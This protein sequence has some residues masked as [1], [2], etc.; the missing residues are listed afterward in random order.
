MANLDSMSRSGGMADAPDSKSGPRKRV[1]VQ[2]PPSV[3][4]WPR[5]SGYSQSRPALPSDVSLVVIGQVQAIGWSSK[6]RVCVIP[7]D[8]RETEWLVQVQVRGILAKDA[9][10]GR[11]TSFSLIEPA[12]KTGPAT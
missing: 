11:S 6:R 3:F 9:A 5:P 7:E 4:R 8:I 12:E 1:W 2:V 10:G